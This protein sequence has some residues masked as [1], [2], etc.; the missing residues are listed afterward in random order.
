MNPEF[1]TCHQLELEA[2]GQNT[3]LSVVSIAML[4]MRADEQIS[5]KGA[6]LA[7]SMPRA[8]PWADLDRWIRP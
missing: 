2:T 3:L 5:H 1:L 6:E 4:S 7:S 8:T